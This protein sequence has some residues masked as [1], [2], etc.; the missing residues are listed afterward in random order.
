MPLIRGAGIIDNCTIVS[1]RQP[2]AQA[3]LASF[4]GG[5]TNC[6]FAANVTG[7][8][9]GAI[10]SLGTA[11]YSHNLAD[12][13]VDGWLFGS[14]EKI[15]VSPATGNWRLLN[16]DR[17]PARNKGDRGVPFPPTDLDGAPRLVGGPDIGC[18]ENQTEF[19]TLIMLR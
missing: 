17:N 3:L 15:F 9:P 10:F 18:Y 7:G 2:A 13:A 6:L 12:V 1:N 4:T 19:R 14:A 8:A 16:G 5:M 11:R